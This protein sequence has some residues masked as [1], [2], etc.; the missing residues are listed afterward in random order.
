VFVAGGPQLGQVESGVVAEL[1]T[2]EASVV[3]GGLA[4]VG[5]VFVAHALVPQVAAYRADIE[6]AR[7]AAT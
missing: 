3:S 6:P 4:C 1:W 2:P 7:A 5:V